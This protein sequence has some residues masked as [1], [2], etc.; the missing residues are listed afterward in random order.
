MRDVIWML[1]FHYFTAISPTVVGQAPEA[2]TRCLHSQAL[3][4][5]LSLML[6]V[7]ELP[8]APTVSNGHMLYCTRYCNWCFTDTVD[9]KLCNV[10]C[11]HSCRNVNKKVLL[12]SV[13]SFI[14]VFVFSLL[15][16]GGASSLGRDVGPSRLH[17]LSVGTQHLMFS[18]WITTDKGAVYL[19]PS[20]L[21]CLS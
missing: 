2:D 21:A 16:G 11:G 10:F 9:G 6:S 14:R 19:P 7:R 1:F 8:G 15:I 20:P 17:L 3:A 18:L 12:Q 4:R 5:A 13:H